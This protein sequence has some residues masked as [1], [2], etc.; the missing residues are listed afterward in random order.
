M[1]APIIIIAS[2]F[3]LQLT[4]SISIQKKWVHWIPLAVLTFISTV[5]FILAQTTKSWNALGFL[6]LSVYIGLSAASTLVAQLLV[7]IV[8]LVQKKLQAKKKP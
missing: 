8:R 7:W 5:L 1:V 4:V 3:A 2:L 6:L